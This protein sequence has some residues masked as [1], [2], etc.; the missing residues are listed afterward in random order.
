MMK[1]AEVLESYKRKKHRLQIWEDLMGSLYQYTDDGPGSCKEYVTMNGAVP[2]DV[3][4]SVIQEINVDIV[5]PLSAELETM[6]EMEVAGGNSTGIQ[7]GK[8]GSEPEAGKKG[9]EAT[10]RKPGKL[11]TPVRGHR[12]ANPQ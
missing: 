11:R 6:E 12:G 4:V 7:E 10:V 1:L 9:S 2:Q 5:K 3:I 8:K